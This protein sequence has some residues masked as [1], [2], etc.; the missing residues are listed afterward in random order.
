[1]RKIQDMNIKIELSIEKEEILID[2]HS[3]NCKIL[4]NI[5]ASITFK[6]G[7]IIRYCE[8]IHS[9]GVVFLKMVYFI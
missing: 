1:M 4:M 5:F 6:I 2:H 9:I 8:P 3:Y 7:F